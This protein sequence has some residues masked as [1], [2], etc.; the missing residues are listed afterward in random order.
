MLQMVTQIKATRYDVIFDQYF[1]PSIKD[2]E[3]SRRHES[4]QLEF[5]IT[6]PDQ[7]R[8]SDF[9]KELKNIHFKQSLVEFFTT[10]WATDEMIPF[11]GNNKIFINFRQ[12]HS[13]T[14]INNKVMS[15]IHE[16]LSCSEHE[17]ADT[18]I[19]YHVCNIDA[20][21]NFVI[22]CSDTDITVI[23]LGNMHHLKNSDSRVWILTGTGN[24][25]RYVDLNAIYEQL[26]PSL[27]R[28]L[29]A[30]H[31]ITGCD[32]NPALFKKGKQKPFNILKKNEEYQQA[33]HR[34]G[35]LDFVG[36]VDEEERVFN[37]IQKFICDVYNV[38]E[39]IDVDA[40]RLQLFINTYM[41]SDINEKFNQ[42]NLRNFDASNLP[43]CKS[44]LWQQ[45][46]RASYIAS[47]WNN[48]SMKMINIFNPENNGWTLQ[49]GKYDFHWFDGDQ[50]PGFVSES[51]E[52]Q[53]EEENKGNAD[54]DDH[55]LD[56]QFQ[57]W[58]DDELS[59]FN[60]D[61]NED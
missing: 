8:P 10:Y 6:G 55:D 46:R 35:T 4:S 49:D 3:R 21:A 12:C 7:V 9:T 58:L 25:Q 23:M 42:K 34:F 38:P 57:D 24:K 59:N 17:E 48:A 56:I 61:D 30:F 18:K 13:F 36:D 19:V 16:D 15:E 29:P 39:I 22:R 5:N 52:E 50:L 11:I 47:L 27:C 41:V 40:A 1:S 33:F 32:F 44:E 37:I 26:G 51:L 31:A 28:S 2:Y 45:F 60:D 43:P 54:D 14:V 53:S 20:Q